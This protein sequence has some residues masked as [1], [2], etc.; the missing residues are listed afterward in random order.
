M[1][2]MQNAKIFTPGTWSIAEQSVEDLAS[3]L[4]FQFDIS[5]SG[6]MYLRLFGKSLPS[7]NRSLAFDKDG[8]DPWA[9]DNGGS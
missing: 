8:K 3:G 5:S 1:G 6:N 4:T 2:S 9:G 7:G